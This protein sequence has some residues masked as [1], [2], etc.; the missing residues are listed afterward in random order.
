MTAVITN[1]GLQL[2]ARRLKGEWNEPIY[3]AWG[4]G[5]GDA[6]IT[7]TT[8]FTEAS[9]SRTA[10]VVDLIG[11]VTDYDTYRVTGVITSNGTKTITNWGLFDASVGGNLLAKESINPGTSLTLGQML[12]FIFRF[13]FERST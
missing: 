7:D 3:I 5:A 2:L 6:S 4:T 9:E 8:L 12:T 13:Q 10:G 11:I 1:I